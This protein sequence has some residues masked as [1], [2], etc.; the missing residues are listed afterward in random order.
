MKKSV[1][2]LALLYFVPLY[3]LSQVPHQSLK[4]RI[5]D[6]QSG[7]GL[8][9]ASV[10]LLG[11]DSASGVI[12]DDD[13]YFKITQVPIGRHAIQVRYLG[14][15]EIILPN[16]LLTSGKEA[17]VE[18]SLQEQIIQSDEVIVKG[19][20]DPDQVRNEF[21]TVSVK[22]FNSE[23]TRRFA[24]SMNDP[25]RMAANYAGVSGAND[26][27]NDIVIRGNSPSGLLWRLE[28][29]DIPNPSHFGS[30]GS[31]GGPVSMLNN[32]VLARSDFFTG[33]FPANYG[34]AMSGVF[35]LRLRNGNR[36][37]REFM[38][39]VGFNGFEVGAEGPF[40]KGKRATYLVNYRYSVLALAQKLGLNRGTGS[41][42][43]E[44]QDITFKIDL[45]TGTKGSRVSLFGIGGNSNVFFKGELK[46]TMNLYNDP[47]SNLSN[48]YKMG[49]A[50][51]TYL[52]Y[53]NDRT[54]WQTS[55][56]AS[57]SKVTTRIDSLS[58]E[59]VGIPQYRDA[60]GQGRF[61][62]STSIN[63][64]IN[65]KNLLSGGLMYHYMTYDL[66]D[67]IRR[68][69][70][71]RVIRNLNGNS[72]LSQGYF[73][74]QLK[75]MN[76]MTINTG[77][78]STY[79]VLNKDFS[80]EPRIGL[81]YNLGSKGV[82]SLAGSLNSQIQP[83]QLY[84][85]RTNVSPNQYLETN[86]NLS[87]TKGAQV[88]LGYGHILGDRVRLKLEGYYQSLKNAPV[89]RRA[90]SFSGL[91]MGA[92]FGATDTD[93]LL[94]N[95]TGRNYGIELTLE[96]FFEDG[97]YFLITTSLFDSK[98]KGSD[99]I[100]RNTAFNTG[101]VG[102][103]LGGKEWKVGKQAMLAVDLKVTTS[104]GRPYIPIDLAKSIMEK[105]QIMDLERAYMVRHRNYFRTDLKFTFRLNQKRF[106][107]EWFIDFQNLT[108]TKNIFQQTYDVRSEKIRIVNQI[109]FNPNINYRVSF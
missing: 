45:P 41:T 4:G 63:S 26:A 88:V 58:E 1:L 99:G 54:S 60:S 18:I 9:G 38:G 21:G 6:A 22:S 49:A 71:F 84:F 64:K 43:P 56:A 46:D 85:I 92:D 52:H 80:I 8:P 107:H 55:L 105:A 66:S 76:R 39:E 95:G 3:L 68:E 109:P 48:A 40:A 35:D 91:N 30:L 83:L 82:L 97:Y 98:V 7:S 77:V 86:R 61:T 13:G 31:T 69:D 93:S 94:S 108:N 24:G 12:S 59:R 10:V 73:Q 104:G 89:E 34:N 103:L 29:I 14:Y 78:H 106:S 50:G 17:Y 33:A 32:N 25:A 44:Y 42:A 16:I 81:Q 74:W 53:I 19:K 27:R 65:A 101:Y 2:Y 62:L 87:M 5:I 90:T 67:S 23:L 102:N 11:F 70:N 51:I 100:L 37:K 28:G 72:A 36:D 15:E 96:R 47:Y 75:P 79:F 57:G 20:R